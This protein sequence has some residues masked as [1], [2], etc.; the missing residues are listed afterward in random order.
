M[1]TPQRIMALDHGSAR[2]GVALSDPL[3]IIASPHTVIQH[4]SQAKDF[5]QLAAIIHEKEV[6]KVVVGLPTDSE[7]GIG[8]QAR[9]VI[10]WARRLAS[11]I[12][13]PVVLWDESYSTEDAQAVQRELR[14]SSHALDAIAAAIILRNYLEV[15]RESAHEPGTPTT[16][17]AED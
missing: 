10:R 7:G 1:T 5:E 12:D 11:A 14:R 4:R 9:T 13:V 17:Q 3:H 6:G 8:E 15:E 16:I 2:I